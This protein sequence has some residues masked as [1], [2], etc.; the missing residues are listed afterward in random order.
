VANYLWLL[1]DGSSRILLN[2]GSDKLALNEEVVA[3]TYG[4][5][6]PLSEPSR[7]HGRRVIAA[8]AALAGVVGPAFTPTAGDADR[9]FASTSA[10]VINRTVI[11]EDRT[12]Y[13]ETPVAA[14]TITVDKWYAPLDTPVRRRVLTD[15]QEYA[16]APH[17][18]FAIAWAKALD[19]PP[20][21]RKFV[22]AEEGSIFAAPPKPEANDSIG[23][24]RALDAPVRRKF[25]FNGDYGY[26]A[27]LPYT[28]D[29]RWAPQLDTPTR[30]KFVLNTEY[31]YG[32]YTPASAASGD[33]DLAFASTSAQINNRT[34]I[35]ESDA[36]APYTPP[37]ETITVDK[38]WR[39]LDI[40]TR[41]KQIT[42]E[43]GSV[44]PA[45]FPYVPWGWYSKLDE[46][47]RVAKSPAKQ[48][49]HTFLAAA[50]GN[51]NAYNWFIPL[52]IPTRARRL[53]E[54][55][56]TSIPV[57]FV[58]PTPG[59][60]LEYNWW[61]QLDEPIRPRK[62]IRTAQQQSVAAPS[63]LLTTTL[64]YAWYQP[65]PTPTRLKLAFGQ[66][67]AI[68]QGNIN[69]V[70]PTAW[71]PLDAPLRI[72]HRHN[73]LA[74]APFAYQPPVIETVTID[75]WWQELARP[76]YTKKIDRPALTPSNIN[77]VVPY[78]W[79][80]LDT[81]HRLK[82]RID[83]PALVQGNVRPEVPYAWHQLDA[84]LRLK[85]RIDRPA[86][87][88]SVFPFAFPGT[89]LGTAQPWPGLSTPVRLK[90]Y[91]HQHNAGLVWVTTFQLGDY[92]PGR[93][94][95]VSDASRQVT[96]N[97]NFDVTP[98]DTSTV[99]TVPLE[100]RVVEVAAESRTVT[101]TQEPSC[102]DS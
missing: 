82:G 30:R 86:H 72:K 76:I 81:P 27:F 62:S 99:V 5:Q 71:Y 67:P 12:T 65:L 79:H 49:S 44:A 14:E 68:A 80:Q 16:Q 93:M 28:N 2:N 21:R 45:P 87:H 74:E 53:Y 3:D 19:T 61:S 17:T 31:G 9:A 94:V 92:D 63:Q 58:P 46:P 43:E 64:E 98:L 60:G 96:V 54:F 97:F 40:P 91:Y 57:Y 75:K 15:P 35:Y 56:A 102:Q 41:R 89:G 13:T 42:A 8:V 4:W 78:A 66:Y 50:P 88:G 48:V 1:N 11:F 52:E 59:S 24:H 34:I 10:Q 33:A 70:V 83:R 36:Y 95:C 77:P 20:T 32:N 90:S 6:P 73:Y 51:N 69:P 39:Q 47:L 37:A 100:S 101:I 85:G 84:P 22:V 29:V 26:T 23:W 7:P 38:W 25:T 18:P 55:P